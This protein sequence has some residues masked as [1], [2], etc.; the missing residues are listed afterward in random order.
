M[1]SFKELRRA[2]REPA[3]PGARKIA[4]LGNCATQFL[5]VAVRGYASLEKIPVT[6]FDADY[7]Q[8]E[9]Q[10][11]GEDSELYRFGPDSVVLWLATEK[12]YEE[13]LDM[14]PDARAGFAQGVMDRLEALWDALGCRCGAKILQCN[15][16]EIPDRVLGNYSAKTPGTFTYQIRK[17]NFLLQ[18]GMAERENVFPVDL[19]ALETELGRESFY[20]APL[21]Y[22]A[23][24][25]VSTAALPYVAKAVCDVEAALTGRIKKCVVVDLDNTLWGGVIGDDG[26]DNIEIGELGRGRVFSDLQRWLRQLRQNGVLLAVCSK[27]DEET[28]KRPFESHPEMVLRL[29]DIAVFVANWEDKAGN[30]R[31]IQQTLNIGMDSIVF[32]DDNPFERELVRKLIPEIQ[33]PELPEDPALVLSFLQGENYFETAGRS[34]MSGDRTKLYQ[35]EF[36]RVKLQ[37]SYRSVDEYL[38]SLEMV[39]TARPFEPAK[40][41]RIAELSMRSN[42]FNLRTVRYTQADIRQIREDPGCL[43]LQLEL[44]DR[45]GDHGLVGVVVG[46]ETGPGELFV[47]SWFMSCRVLKRGMEEFTVNKLMEAARGRGFKR[48]VGEYIPTPKNAMVRD[49]YKSMGFSPIG[50][51]RY[52]M[53]VNRYLEKKTFIKEC[54]E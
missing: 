47:E 38:E 7:D 41:P 44:R 23:R 40:F 17:L 36:Q 45:F 2:A 43:T 21:Y 11:L 1:Y 14:A 52:A 13:F 8:I 35:A 27:N 26:M 15:F 24:M 19:L 16:T 39:G 4:L 42:Q 48:V 50:E 10:V 22:S 28:A 49:I 51:N 6:V 3:G 34:G 30:I 31:L 9:A 20:D 12:L 25:T 53:E 37:A 46:R 32:L 29:D 54:A 33:V 5:A 18:E